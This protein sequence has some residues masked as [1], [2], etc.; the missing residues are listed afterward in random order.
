MKDKKAYRIG[1]GQAMGLYSDGGKVPT[2]SKSGK[3]WMGKANLMKHLKIVD[4]SAY[5][6]CVI[7]AYTLDFVFLYESPLS[8]FL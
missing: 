4:P 1:D 7:L 6:G 5:K 2:W 8:F 3:I